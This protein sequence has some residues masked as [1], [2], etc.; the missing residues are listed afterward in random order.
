MIRNYFWGDQLAYLS[1]SASGSAG[2]TRDV[3][4]FTETGRSIYPSGFYAIVGWFSRLFHLPPA[5]ALNLIF[6]LFSVVLVILIARAL[7]SLFDSQ[8]AAFAVLVPLL[9]GTMNTQTTGNW[10]FGLSTHAVIWPMAA[11]LFAANAESLSLLLVSLIMIFLVSARIHK[12]TDR[13]HNKLMLSA[14]FLGVLANSHTYALI[15]GMTITVVLLLDQTITR[16][17]RRFVIPYIPR[18]VQI[19]ILFIAILFSLAIFDVAPMARLLVLWLVGFGLIG[20]LTNTRREK[21]QLLSFLFTSAIVAIPQIIKTGEAF[22]AHDPF[23]TS[24]QQVSATLSVPMFDLIFHNLPISGLFLGACFVAQRNRLRIYLRVNILLYFVWLFLSFNQM[25]GLSQEPYRFAINAQI[26]LAIFA[27]ATII[28]GW[29]KAINTQV[30]K[31]FA[32][33]GV[34]LLIIPSSLEIQNFWTQRVN[35]GVIQLDSD[36]NQEMLSVVSKAPPGLLVPDPC[37][38]P[39][40]LKVIS[41]KKLAVYSKGLAWP[42]NVALIEKIV[43]ARVNNILDIAS[44]KQLVVAAILIDRECPVQWATLYATHLKPIGA[45]PTTRFQLYE[46]LF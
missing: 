19:G 33:F 32:C 28:A 30:L 16:S 22:V 20:I 9:L 39:A 15:L 29:R 38:E 23:L 12:S 6:V 14:V 5:S 26:P 31:C 44:A 45:D 7:R 25:W 43:D 46:L 1:I 21:W 17:N 42:D 4:P 37:I 18:I 34:V 36:V 24:R 13:S 10:S 11:G 41:R 35:A 27:T 40:I 3:E 2:L 8:A